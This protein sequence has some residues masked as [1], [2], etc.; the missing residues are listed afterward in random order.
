MLESGKFTEHIAKRAKILQIQIKQKKIL[1]ER[2]KRN[3]ELGALKRYANVVDFEH[4]CKNDY[5]LATLGF[6]KANN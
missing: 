1:V 5:L 2:K 3:V 6:D 4:G